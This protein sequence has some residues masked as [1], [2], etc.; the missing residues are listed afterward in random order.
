VICGAALVGAVGGVGF[1]AFNDYL[2]GEFDDRT[3]K[4]NLAT[5]GVAAAQ[6]TIVGAGTAV[7]TITAPA[8]L[9]GVAIVG[10]TAGALNVGTTLTGNYFLGQKTDSTNL[11]IGTTVSVLTAGTLRTL[12][13]VPGRLPNFGTK[14]FYS[15]AHTQRQAA[16][17][18]FSSS[19]STFA[20]TT[21][22]FASQNYSVVVSNSGVGG[23]SLSGLVQQLQSLVSTLQSLVSSLS[24]GKSSQ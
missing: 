8:G 21:S 4:E 3:W 17:E 14:A 12:P 9:T 7:A 1:Q 16:E 20:Q 19:V 23:S 15:G 11:A 10:G 5:Y 24:G 2:S 18:L 6:G 13:Q 22:R